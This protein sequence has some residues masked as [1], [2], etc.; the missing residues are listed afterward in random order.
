M[1]KLADMALFV[2]IINQGSL[3]A[4]GKELNLSPARMTARLQALERTL[5]VKLVN[6]TTRQLAITDAGNMYYQS[7]VEILERVSMA[8][9]QLQQNVQQAKGSLKIAAPKDLGK[10]YIL[11]LLDAFVE[12]HPQVIPHLY[13]DDHIDNIANA[14]VDV[15]IRYG[16]MPDSSFISRTL[17]KSQRLLCASPKYLAKYGTPKHPVDLHSHQCIAM[18]RSHEELSNWHF[19]SSDNS[20]RVTLQ[21]NR[22]S[23]D[24]EIVRLWALQ[25]KGIALKSKLDVQQDIEQGRLLTIL[26]D[27]MTDFDL[28][29]SQSSA[30]LHLVYLNRQY[31]PYR[32]QLFIQFLV[33][34][35]Q[36]RF[37][38]NK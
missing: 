13:F 34:E 11:P 37:K 27:Y 22:F 24:G 3:A 35:F 15:L 31:Q 9:S 10:Q 2:T 28:S 21:P 16:E 6:R 1:N 5:G 33:K 7:C 25:G 29:K 4:A 18:L 30:D 38:I 17:A 32:I 12:K 36:Q 23:D 19:H 8:E 20:S 26:D 14:G